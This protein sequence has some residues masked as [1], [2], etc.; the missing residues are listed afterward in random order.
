MLS[1]RIPLADLGFDHLVL[2]E[3]HPSEEDFRRRWSFTTTW[4]TLHPGLNPVGYNLVAHRLPSRGG[5]ASRT[6]FRGAHGSRTRPW[7]ALG[8][9]LWRSLASST[10]ADMAGWLALRSQRYRLSR[11]P[12]N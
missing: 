8:E 2:D 9:L 6:D 3:T 12:R 1:N 5:D 10:D 11:Q 7:R 4:N